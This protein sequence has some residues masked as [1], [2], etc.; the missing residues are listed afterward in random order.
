M[1]MRPDLVRACSGYHLPKKSVDL[2]AEAQAR[3]SCFSYLSPT[4]NASDN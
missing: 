3:A 1:Q 4:R 2:R